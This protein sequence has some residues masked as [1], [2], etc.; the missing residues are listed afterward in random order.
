[1]TRFIITDE[2]AA[3]ERMSSDAPKNWH[4]GSGASSE[5]LSV[6]GTPFARANAVLG[7]GRVI[8]DSVA[9]T[10]GSIAGLGQMRPPPSR[11]RWVVQRFLHSRNSSKLVMM[12][13][14][15]VAKCLTFVK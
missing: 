14:L 11:T 13:R 15:S 10:T 3:A 8:S 5:R 1:M 12:L 4:I 7:D 2:T 6:N 9:P